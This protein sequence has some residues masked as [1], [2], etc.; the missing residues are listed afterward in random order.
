MQAAKDIGAGRVVNPRPCP[1]TP[2]RM[3][4]AKT[5]FNLDKE[6]DEWQIRESK[7]INHF[8]FTSTSFN[9]YEARDLIKEMKSYPGF[10]F[11]RANSSDQSCVQGCVRGYA[12]F[13][14]DVTKEELMYKFPETLWEVPYFMQGVAALV[15][16]ATG[17]GRADWVQHGTPTGC[18]ASVKAN[19]MAKEE[20][21]NQSQ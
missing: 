16:K 11:L 13:E 9:E 19:I 12:Q 18:S 7:S 3:K 1:D 21:P 20:D 6:E 14:H 17:W 4:R 5:V 10:I 15:K 8:L 2:P